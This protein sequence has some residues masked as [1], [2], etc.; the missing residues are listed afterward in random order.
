MSENGVSFNIAAIHSYL[1]LRKG[2]KCYLWSYLEKEKENTKEM[3]VFQL[4][5]SLNIY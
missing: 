4:I 5:Y 3:R 1:I 2:S